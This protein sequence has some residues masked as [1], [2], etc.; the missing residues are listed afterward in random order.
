[1]SGTTR[2]HRKMAKHL[3][4]KMYIKMVRIF[5]KFWHT[6]PVRV[7][8]N[9]I[10]IQQQWKLLHKLVVGYTS[11]GHLYLKLDIILV[12]KKKIH[13]LRVVFQDNTMYVRTSFRG[14]KTSQIGKKGCVFGHIDKFGKGNDGQIKK[15]T[16]KN[17]YRVYFHTWKICV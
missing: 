7:T 17:M 6:C 14:A 11:G 13:V 16:C 9:Q 15:N 4:F 12:K 8:V 10:S 3:S 2:S 1:M 5:V